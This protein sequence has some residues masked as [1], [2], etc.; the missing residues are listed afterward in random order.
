[1]R[2]RAKK[3]DIEKR[4]KKPGHAGCGPEDERGK[5]YDKEEIASKAKV[6]GRTFE[7]GCQPALLSACYC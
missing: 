7:K 5:V 1:M 4:T 6:S 2:K 3:D